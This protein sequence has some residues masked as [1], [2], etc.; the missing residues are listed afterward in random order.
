V[1][2]ADTYRELAPDYRVRLDPYDSKTAH[3]AAECQFASVSEEAVL[4]LGL[5]VKPGMG[6]DYELGDARRL[7][8]RLAGSALR[9]CRAT[10]HRRQESGERLRMTRRHRHVPAWTASLSSQPSRNASW[11][12]SCCA[13]RP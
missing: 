1:Y 5:K 10:T 3:H 4:R 2:G 7:R 13:A 12:R 9:K 6:P 8:L 11:S